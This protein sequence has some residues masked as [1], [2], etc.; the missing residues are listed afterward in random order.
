[1]F[2]CFYTV[3]LYLIPATALG[4][5]LVVSGNVG[6]CIQ[7]LYGFRNGASVTVILL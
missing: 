3:D 4:L 2:V 5:F 1:M 7:M 6:Y